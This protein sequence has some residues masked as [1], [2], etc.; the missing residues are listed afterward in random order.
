[1]IE[2]LFRHF[3]VLV[4]D[5]GTRRL[6]SVLVGTEHA[7]ERLLDL[8]TAKKA[9]NKDRTKSVLVRVGES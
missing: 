7:L 4:G 3:L 1:L 2:E 6:S 8:K 5:H 9:G